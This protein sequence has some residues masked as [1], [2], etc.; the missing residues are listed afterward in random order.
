MLPSQYYSARAVYSEFTVEYFFV[1]SNRWSALPKELDPEHNVCGELHAQDLGPAMCTATGPRSLDECEGWFQALWDKEMTWLREALEESTAE[2]QIVVTHIHPDPDQWEDLARDYGIDLF[3]TGQEPRQEVLYLDNT[4][5]LRPSGVINAGGGG[6]LVSK[7]APDPSGKDSQYG[8]MDLTLS[9]ETI[10]VELVSRGGKVVDSATIHQRSPGEEYDGN[11]DYSHVR[12]SSARETTTVDSLAMTKT[13]T[14]EQV[15]SLAKTT[16]SV[17]GSGSSAQPSSTSEAPSQAVEP[18]QAPVASEAASAAAADLTEIG[19][20][21]FD[22][23]L[24]VTPLTDIT[25]SVNDTVV[26]NFVLESVDYDALVAQESTEA[27]MVKGLREVV[28]NVTEVGVQGVEV[29]LS[30]GS[31]AVETIIHAGDRSASEIKTALASSREFG[32]ALSKFLH[33]LEGMEAVSTGKLNFRPAGAPTVIKAPR[34]KTAART[35]P[36]AISG[37][38][39][40]IPG[41]ISSSIPDN[42]IW[43]GCAGA[44]VAT[45]SLIV[46]LVC[47][48]NSEDSKRLPVSTQEDSASPLSSKLDPLNSSLQVN[49]SLDVGQDMKTRVSALLTRRPGEVGGASRRGPATAAGGSA[50][51]RS[52]SP[53]DPSGRRAE[54]SSGFFTRTALF[55]RGS[56]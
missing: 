2:W 48:R 19:S 33:E 11:K 31:V 29:N 34:P 56:S 24:R 36:T 18:T 15:D 8:F 55:S 27:A 25:E 7:E 4:N 20:D 21:G 16:T 22:A 23:S 50:R 6:G 30:R 14:T 45:L 41:S 47:R 28:A 1:D 3:L 32:L 35:Q 46:C 52:Q 9:K 12:G 13:T 40:S 54:G 38:P 43:A 44:A 10:K 26:F 42:A 39:I 49:T 5:A 17:R 51:S 37:M 53:Q